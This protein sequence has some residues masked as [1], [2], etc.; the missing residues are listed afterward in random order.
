MKRVD[1]RLK[2]IE[3]RKDTLA[4]YFLEPE[5]DF[6]LEGTF[7]ILTRFCKRFQEAHKVNRA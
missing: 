1:E 4:K 7:E 6:N 5:K 3:K 2:D